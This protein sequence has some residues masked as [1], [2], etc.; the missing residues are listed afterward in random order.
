[1]F[2]RYQSLRMKLVWSALFCILIP[3]VIIY[4]VTNYVTKDMILNK[5]I[6]NAEDTLKVVE[7]EINGMMEKSFELSNFVLM[8]NEIRQ[9]LSIKKDE[10]VSTQEKQNY[11]LNYSRLIRNLDDL[12]LRGTDRY[13]TILGANEPFYTNYS[14]SDYDPALLYDKEWISELNWLPQ[15]SGL[16]M[17]ERGLLDKRDM[18][19]ITLGRPI[20]GA[21]STAIGYMIVQVNESV[22]RTH[23]KRDDGQEL[24]LLDDEGV[25]MSHVDPSRIG[26][27][28]SWWNEQRASNTIVING[29]KYIIIEHQIA[30]NNWHVV[31]LIPLKEEIKK[32]SEILLISFLMQA[33]FFTIFF[34]LLTLRITSI[35]KPIAELSRFVTS[36]GR[37][38]LNMRN[39]IREANEVGHLARTIDHMLD[40]IEGMIEQ[41]T[42]EQTKK[43]KAEL[44]LLQ[45]QINPHFMFN[46]LNSIRMN[47][48]VEG[49]KENAELIGALSSLLRMT[50]NRDNE[51]ITL[52]EEVD[53]IY[54]Y[55]KL[56]N[57]RHANQVRLHDQLEDDC[58]QTLVP[59]FMIQPFIENAIIHG[60]EQYD[61]DIYIEAKQQHIKGEPFIHISIRDNGIGMSKEKLAELYSKIENDRDTEER[62]S[63]SF[64]GIGVKNVFQRLKL[65][66]GYRFDSDIQ[67]EIGLGTTITLLFPIEKSRR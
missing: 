21:T 2:K 15:Y 66:Y 33:L 38:Q 60:F 62:L 10:L 54:H 8:N 57:F 64:S 24:M 67:S 61:G 53:T 16:W 45:A 40:R 28:M 52:Q 19:S 42:V 47:I 30:A 25:I 56:M 20:K 9:M 37:G 32:N 39:G 6:R 58:K 59:R 63:N 50:I 65:V 27:T 51:Y 26:E 12:F 11:A 46:L 49:D 3:L 18:Y 23:L 48:L 5:V 14:H 36:I 17:G 7:T 1:M 55:L 35:T 13:V 34:I 31:R 41:I 44:E 29:L 22:I 43:R 4:L